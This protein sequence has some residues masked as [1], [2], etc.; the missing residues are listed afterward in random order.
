MVTFFAITTIVIAI[1]VGL[2]WLSPEECQAEA[3]EESWVPGVGILGLL[4]AD[5]V[6]IGWWVWEVW[7]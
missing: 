4:I 6:A 2:A 7:R 1:V 5:G 3:E